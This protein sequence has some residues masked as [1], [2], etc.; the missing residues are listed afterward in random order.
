[1]G[2]FYSEVVAGIHLQTS[3]SGQQRPRSLNEWKDLDHRYL[4]SFNG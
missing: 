2:K 3:G 4:N 1:M